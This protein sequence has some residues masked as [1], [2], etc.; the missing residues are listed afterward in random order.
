MM[1]L[2]IDSDA[3]EQMCMALEEDT[4]RRFLLAS[5]AHQEELTDETKE[6][7]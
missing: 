1:S 7:Q 5:R 4:H 3:E 2:S 6:V